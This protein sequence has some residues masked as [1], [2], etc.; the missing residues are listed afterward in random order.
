[1][2]ISSQLQFIFQSFNSVLFKGSPPSKKKIK[3]QTPA[4]SLYRGRLKARVSLMSLGPAAMQ[5]A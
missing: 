3:L 4:S 5:T 1:M 2:Y